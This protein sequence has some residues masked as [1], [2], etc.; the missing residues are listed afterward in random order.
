MAFTETRK[1]FWESMT[2][3]PR[4]VGQELRSDTMSARQSLNDLQEREGSLLPVEQTQLLD[5][6]NRMGEFG[7]STDA[8]RREELLRSGLEPQQKMNEFAFIGDTLSGSNIEEKEKDGKILF[9]FKDKSGRELFESDDANLT[10]QM[11]VRY[12]LGQYP[13]TIGKNIEEINKYEQQKKIDA[14]YFVPKEGSTRDPL[15]EIAL[16]ALLKA[17]Q[18][19]EN[20]EGVESALG[21]YLPSAFNLKGKATQKNNKKDSSNEEKQDPWS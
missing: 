12:G 20:L 21:S 2:N 1:A 13:D 11:A 3:T 14:R 4:I 6:Q 7:Q 9:V 8:A 16:R 15:S 17:A 10:A 19:G 5:L 18:E